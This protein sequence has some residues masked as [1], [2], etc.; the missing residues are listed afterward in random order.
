M[1]GIVAI[2]NSKANVKSKLLQA[3][4]LLRHRGPDSSGIIC[5]EDYG[6]A[7]ER[8]AI[9]DPTSEAQ[10][11]VSKQGTI[12][13]VNGEIYNHSKYKHY[14]TQTKSDCEII[15]HLYDDGYRD[16]RLLEKLDG[17]YS[18]VIYNT[19]SKQLFVARDMF[20]VIPL[21]YG[22]G[23]DGC[24]AFASEM[25]ALKG[26]VG[27]IKEFPPGA[28]F[29]G[30]TMCRLIRSWPLK[31]AEE[32]IEE[33]MDNI[34]HKLTFAT[35]K[36]L[37]S[38][39]QYGFLLSGGLD[40]SIIAAIGSRLLTKP[41]N[42]FCIGLEGSEDT[43]Y[44][45][46][47]ADHIGSKHFAFT[48]TVDEGWDA[49]K[50]VIFHLETFDTT[51]IR[52]GVP[53]YLLARKIRAMGCKMV[54]SGE[55]ADEIFGGYLYFHNA[56][57]KQDFHDET[58]RKVLNL[59]RYDNLRANKA[60]AAFGVECRIPF[61]DREFVEYCMRDINP[62]LK[63]PKDKYEKWILRKTFENYL[64][65]KIMW[66]RKEQF[67]D[68]VGHAWIDTLKKKTFEQCGHLM[69]KA[70]DFF[71]V[72]TPKTP[73]A[74]YYRMLFESMFNIPGSVQTVPYEDSCACSTGIAAQWSGNEIHDASGRSIS[75]HKDY[76]Q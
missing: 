36:R 17:V 40:S 50:N 28:F 46:I 7:H 1:C 13:A 18:F 44:A 67:S 22:Y 5:A 49:I 25:K 59:H 47:M 6:I 52:A 33:C 75:I 43:K 15:M 55:G 68:G 64:P 32:K 24:I 42:T 72:S 70:T 45:Q 29:N 53:L 69:D 34:F 63:M 16:D 73:E 57:D 74:F 27:N 12:L 23:Y 4:A 8:L 9:I 30:K 31:T 65:E 39:V 54:L 71:P 11:F 51:T 56:K 37:M 38:S 62:V 66:R 3:S 35:T 20:G 10:P 48:Y 41:I 2:F 14:T 61:L 19:Q 21:Y 58:V 60:M 76:K 26:I